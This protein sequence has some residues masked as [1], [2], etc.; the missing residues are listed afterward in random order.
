[1]NANDAELVLSAAVEWLRVHHRSVLA[2]SEV[3][4]VR[5]ALKDRV[6]DRFL[7]KPGQRD[8]VVLAH[9]KVTQIVGRRRDQAQRGEHQ[10][11]ARA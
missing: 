8:L 10:R 6:H 5:R 1:M 4:E 11:M 2:P 9:A 7:G 3:A